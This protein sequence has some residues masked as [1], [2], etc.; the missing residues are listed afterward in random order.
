MPGGK[1]HKIEKSNFMDE[2][3]AKTVARFSAEVEYHEKL[4][5]DLIV[6]SYIPSK[7]QLAKEFTKGL[8][9]EVP[10]TYWPLT[11]LK[12]SVVNNH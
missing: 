9:I 1:G 4:D 12:E 8:P 6:T 7:L 11:N 5:S 3:E 2:Q 10:R